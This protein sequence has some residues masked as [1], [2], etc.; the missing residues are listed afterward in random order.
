MKTRD[1]NS[2]NW[3][4]ILYEDDS[5][6]TG[7]RWKID[8]GQRAK[9]GNIAGTISTNNKTGRKDAHVQFNK[10]TWYVHR[11]LWILRN[12]EID[13]NL[14]IDHIDGNPLN[15]HKEN[16]RLVTKRINARNQKRKKTNSSGVNGVYFMTTNGCT[17]AIA[18]WY[19]LTH[20]RE[21]KPFSCK[22]LGL[23]PAFALACAYR[24]K[25]IEKLNDMGAGYSE[26]H[27]ET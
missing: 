1:Y 18:Q 20:T 12:G 16:V 9:S 2:V 13:I 21:S 15:N 23:L 11:I 6:P 7:S 10:K 5:S 8:C 27:G 17:Y 3:N 22:N 26:R 25:M 24:E 4:E 19:N 14:D